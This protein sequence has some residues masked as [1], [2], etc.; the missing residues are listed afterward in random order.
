MLDSKTAREL[1]PLVNTPD[2]DEL[3]LIYLDT[4]KEDAY[5]T[6][7]QSDDE[8][9]IYRAQGQL[10]ILKRM[11]GMRLEIQTLAKGE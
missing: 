4:K 6:L 8:V 3:L 1:L 5:R 10:H 9:K 2:F 11:E 7:E